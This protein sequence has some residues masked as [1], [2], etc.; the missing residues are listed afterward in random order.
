MKSTSD[1]TLSV[2]PML[3][4]SDRH[5]RYFWR[6]LSKNIVLYTEMVTAGAIIYG[7]AD[8]HLRFNAEEHP[9]VLQLG[10]SDTEALA[11]C[12]KIAEQYG[13]DGINLNVGCPSDRVK[14]GRFGACLMAEP[15]LVADCVRAMKS[16][17]KLPV[18][19]KTRIGIDDQDSYDFLKTFAK[20]Q[21]DAKADALIVH[22]RKAWLKGLSPKQNREIPPLDYPR[23]HQLKKDFPDLNIQ[24]NGGFEKLDQVVFQQ[25]LVDGVMLG[26]KIYHDPYFLT[27]LEAAFYNVQP[28]SRDNVLTDYLTY[29]EK[30]R[31]SGASW[32]TLFK[33]LMNLYKGEAGG[34]L[35]R[36]RLSEYAVTKADTDVPPSLD[37]LRAGL[38]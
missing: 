10:G 18:T 36:Q 33:P 14:K 9:V 27:E 35:F 32:H 34:R 5:A 16:V 3:D 28:P 31:E 17:V 21:I 30:A 7:D 4:W 8:R 1:F 26:R 15:E 23:V 20:H 25:G 11:E 29:A 13:Y 19:V 12:A 24:I 38:L 6:L 37:C 2:A 22:A